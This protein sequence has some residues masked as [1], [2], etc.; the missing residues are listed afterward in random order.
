MAYAQATGK[1]DLLDVALKSADLLAQT[2]GPGREEIWPG[3]QITEMALVKLTRA[4]G[5]SRYLEL[6]KFMLDQ[7]GPDGH[8]GSGREYNQ[9]HARVV[10]QAEAVGHAVRATYMYSGMADVAA[11]TGDSGYIRAID[12]IWD[13]VVTGQLYITGGIGA[14][15]E[16]EAFG[17]PNELPNLTAYCETC[18][19]IGNVFW[20]HRLFLLHGDGCYVDVLERTLYNALLAG[21]SL[22]GM[23]F[24]YENPLESAGGYERSPWFGCAC[25]PSNVARFLP[26]LPGYVY[27]QQGASLYVNLF[28]AGTAEIEMGEGR[29]IGLE[30]ET[31]YPWDG[32]VKLRVG[33]E[34]PSRFTVK[35]RVPGWARNEVVPSDLYR[36]ADVSDD[37]VTLTV[38]GERVGLELEKGYACLGREWQA[39]DEIELDLPMPVRQVVAH[40]R[41]EANR[42]RVV[43]QRGPLVYCVEGVDYPEG[44]VH[45]LAVSEDAVLSAEFAP[46]LLGGVVVVKA[47]ALQGFVAI[48]YFA[49][50]NRGPGEMLVWMPVAGEN[51][52]EGSVG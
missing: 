1:G 21:V 7:R 30:Q 33:L 20:N 18:A 22:D 31:A 45:E 6:A 35:L 41:V 34:G 29:V 14:T 39:G 5:D 17:G 48:P 44:R 2:F 36:F 51:R 47:E 15:A 40:E 32:K 3:H 12:R 28:V 13:D 4:T 10:E 26:S 43:L 42:G 8:E 37:E 19:S 11:L 9:S 46:D 16:G 50:A 49:W 27:A 24:F 38:N 25:C 52:I 23:R